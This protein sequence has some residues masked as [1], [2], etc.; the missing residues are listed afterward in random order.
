MAGS[1]L[2]GAVVPFVAGWCG[3]GF[4]A[5]LAIG[6]CWWFA[7]LVA[8]FRPR[9]AILWVAVFTGTAAAVNFWGRTAA[10]MRGAGDWTVFWGIWAFLLVFSLPALVLCGLVGWSNR[11]FA[12]RLRQLRGEADGSRPPS[13]PA[14]PGAADRPGD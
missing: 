14:E 4:G 5:Y 1:I 12:E 3:G 13:N 2:G 8:C 10:G 11:A 9:S 6:L 7:G